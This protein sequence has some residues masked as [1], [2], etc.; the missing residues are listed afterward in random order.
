LI[1]WI[2]WV[3]CCLMFIVIERFLGSGWV[4]ALD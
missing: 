1:R 4:S 2:E 3:F